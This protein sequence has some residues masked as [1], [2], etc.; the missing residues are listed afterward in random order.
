MRDRFQ[1]CRQFRY[2]GEARLLG[3]ANEYARQE[4]D[5]SFGA[6]DISAEP[7]EI[8][9]RAA[10]EVVAR[11]AQLDGLARGWKE[12]DLADGAF[13]EH[14]GV[15]AAAAFLQR[16]NHRLGRRSNARQA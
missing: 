13:G 16:H 9:G 11:P 7:K 6:L 8:V 15:L 3:E 12:A 5:E 2:I 10:G 1:E 14:P 4:S